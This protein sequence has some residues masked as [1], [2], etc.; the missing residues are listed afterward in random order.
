MDPKET[1]ETARRYAGF[2]KPVP[3]ELHVF[4]GDGNPMALAPRVPWN[5]GRPAAIVEPY[6]TAHH[7]RNAFDHFAKG[8]YDDELASAGCGATGEGVTLAADSAAIRR[9]FLVV[10]LRGVYA[11]AG[12]GDGT[13]QLQGAD[14]DVYDLLAPHFNLKMATASFNIK[15]ERSYACVEDFQRKFVDTQ[16]TCVHTPWLQRRPFVPAYQHAPSCACMP[17]HVHTLVCSNT[18]PA[19]PRNCACA[20]L[21]EVSLAGAVFAVRTWTCSPAHACARATG[22]RG[23]GM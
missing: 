21:V 6:T 23:D 10:P 4:E 7:Q 2:P 20:S 12:D 17:S 11:G 14:K 19:A 9:R 16:G 22:N 13:P 3:Q 18:V 5:R 1:L 15:M 8:D